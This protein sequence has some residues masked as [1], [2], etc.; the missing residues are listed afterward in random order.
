MCTSFQ[1]KFFFRKS[2]YTLLCVFFFQKNK[3]VRASFQRKFL[4]T[5]LSMHVC[6]QNFS[7]TVSLHEYLNG[8]VPFVKGKFVC[9]SYQYKCLFRK[10]LLVFLFSNQNKF[11]SASFQ[12]KFLC[13]SLSMHVCLQNFS[14]TVSLNAYLNGIVPF[15]KGKFVCA[16]YQYKCLFRQSL[17]VFLFS[18]KTS[19]FA[20]AFNASFSAQVPAR[21]PAKLLNG[22]FSFIKC[23]YV[24]AISQCKCL[25]ASLWVQAGAPC[26]TQG[27]RCQHSGPRFSDPNQREVDLQL[28]VWALGPGSRPF[29]PAEAKASQGFASVP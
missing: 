4:C 13:T 14:M 25:C 15:V 24:C 20:Q 16:S 18:I 29:F 11:V 27:A 8:I 6:L 23:K 5:S 12:R 2:L 17:L 7:M 26:S 21:L 28:A 22:S 3:F 19:L 9:A 10:S 1:C